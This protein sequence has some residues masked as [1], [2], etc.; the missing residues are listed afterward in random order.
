MNSYAKKTGFTLIEILIAVAI[1]V[2]IVS[3]V[4]G[5][6]RAASSSAQACEEKMELSQKAR[7][8][9][10]QMVR[11]IRC[12]YIDKC[13]YMAGADKLAS[14]KLQKK[15]QNKRNYFCGDPD[16]LGGEVIR[17]VTTHCNFNSA[18]S[19]DGLFDVIY[20]FDANNSALFISESRFISTSREPAERANWKLLLENVIDINLAFYDGQTWVRRWDSDKIDLPS[21][22]RVSLAVE[23]KKYRQHL[24]GTTAYLYCANDTKQKYRLKIADPVNN[25]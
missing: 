7:A 22:V 2:T 14:Q 15:L 20:K 23:D 19:R 17:I 13:E 12:A 9:L 11:Q 24:F 5:S 3:V 6:Y 25:K 21:A 4:Y 16:D 1:T 10:E 8:V 18:G